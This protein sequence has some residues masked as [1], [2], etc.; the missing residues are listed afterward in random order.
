MKSIGT[1]MN[2]G[3]SLQLFRLLKQNSLCMFSFH[4]ELG[5]ITLRLELI[6][7]VYLLGR[8]AWQQ[9]L[10]HPPAEFSFLAPMF[11]LVNTI[12]LSHLLSKRSWVCISSITE[13]KIIPAKKSSLNLSCLWIYWVVQKMSDRLR[14]PTPST[15]ASSRN[16]A[17]VFW[18]TLY[19]D[20]FW[21]TGSYYESPH[22]IWGKISWFDQLL[23]FV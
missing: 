20:S 7:L 15:V 21:H 1:R 11:A 4:D 9:Y 13:L 16:L 14:E 12:L 22:Q 23:Q 17:E 5:N 18:T 3:M 8:E 19:I 10:P 6:W 2:L